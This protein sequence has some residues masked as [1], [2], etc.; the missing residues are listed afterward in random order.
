MV[1]EPFDFIH[2]TP[3]Q[4]APDFIKQSPFANADGWAEVDMATLRHPRYPE[5]FA[6]GDASS[7]PTSKTAAA[8][9]SQI[10]V[11]VE[12]LLRALQGG[13]ADRQY[14]GYTA[15]PITTSYQSVLLAE[16]CYGGKVTPSFPLDPTKERRS[17]WHL[18]KDFFPKF[19]WH[20]ML[21]GRTWDIGH[22]PRA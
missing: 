4:S 19:Y 13:S 16:F 14:D 6:L 18:K 7:A 15:C 20:Y 11:V 5:V 10:P 9:R 8:V 22:R 3:P 2:V 12:N 17:M 1:E 21:K